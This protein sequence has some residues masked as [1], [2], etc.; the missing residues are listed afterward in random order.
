MR[1]GPGR[2]SHLGWRKLLC[3][4]KPIRT[5]ILRVCLGNYYIY[6]MLECL[7]K[8]NLV[9]RLT[10]IFNLLKYVRGN[11]QSVGHYHK[12]HPDTERMGLIS[13]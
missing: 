9:S 7:A 3:Y 1:T 4:N 12:I 5:K 6:G 10:D 8:S 11:V 13:A 2:P